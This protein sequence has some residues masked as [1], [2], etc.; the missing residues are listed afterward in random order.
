MITATSSATGALASTATAPK[1]A[2]L[3]QADFLRLMTAQMSAQDPFAPMDNSQFLAQLAQFSQVAGIAEMNAS[4]ST[5]ASSLG[6]GRLGDTS[7]WIGKD[8]LIPSHI[9]APANGL[10]SGEIALAAP[11]PSAAT[12]SFVDA[13][14]TILHS[15]SIGGASA[16]RSAW[17]WDG[18]RADGT[19]YAGPVRLVVGGVEQGQYEASSWSTVRGIR[20]PGGQGQAQIVTDLG[21]V[22][23]DSIIQVG[24]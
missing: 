9:A 21:A 6:Q 12:L 16:G 2:S 1:P 23:P 5:I 17:S 15:Q 3:G 13:G 10:Y 8:V 14:G 20:A 18:K 11:A 22:A 19:T 4:L 24:R 7:A